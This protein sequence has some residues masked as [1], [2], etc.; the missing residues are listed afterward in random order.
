MCNLGFYT[1]H[2]FK[3]CAWLLVDS[4]GRNFMYSSIMYTSSM[5]KVE[6][7]IM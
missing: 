1:S 5:H 4:I 7:I 3:Y 6:L 2:S